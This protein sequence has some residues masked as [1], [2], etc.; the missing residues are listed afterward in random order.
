MLKPHSAPQINHKL[1]LP[2]GPQVNGYLDQY[3]QQ[4][5]AEYKAYTLD[6]YRKLKN[7]MNVKLGMLGPDLENDTHKERVRCI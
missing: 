4:K 5:K 7:D 6:D 1:S 2:E 3:R